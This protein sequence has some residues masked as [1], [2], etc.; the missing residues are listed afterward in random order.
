MRRSQSEEW[1][2]HFFFFFHFHEQ[3]SFEEDEGRVWCWH[4]YNKVIDKFVKNKRRIEL[5]Y[6]KK[7][8]IH[9]IQLSL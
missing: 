6:K 1:L 8:I 4:F 7:M 9:I 5:I 3:K 2:I